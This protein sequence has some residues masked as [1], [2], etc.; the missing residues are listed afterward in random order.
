MRRIVSIVVVAVLA[1]TCCCALGEDRYTCQA[2]VFTL[3]AFDK[4]P[5]VWSPDHSKHVQ[6]FSTPF[7]DGNLSVYSREALLTTITLD[8]VSAGTFIK[9]APDSNAFYVMWSDGGFIGGYHVRAFL[10]TDK[11]ATESLAPKNVAAE[12]AQHHYCEARGN[13]LYAIR[14]ESGSKELLLEP[15]VY[16][17]GDC[18]KDLGFASGYLVDTKSGE[19]KQRYTAKQVKEMAKGCPS[20]VFP[21]AF[22]TQEAVDSALKKGSQAK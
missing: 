16:P 14:W 6:L 8:D 4:K 22:T 19:I 10:V 13:N 5:I 18:G 2:D 11:Q 21:N 15:E 20:S 17:T 3:E 7:D 1:G 12:F 9:W